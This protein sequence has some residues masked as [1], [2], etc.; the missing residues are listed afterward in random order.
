[1]TTST[2]TLKTLTY[3]ITS[4]RMVNPRDIAWERRRRRRRRRRK[5]MSKVGFACVFF[6]FVCLLVLFYFLQRKLCCFL[7]KI[8][9]QSRIS[10]PHACLYSIIH[11][12]PRPSTAGCSPLPM[13]SNCLSFA[14]LDHVAPCL[15]TS[16][17]LQSHFCLLIDDKPP[18]ICHSV[19]LIIHPSSFIQAMCPA[20]FRFLLLT[21]S[22]MSVALV[23]CQMMVFLILSFY[24]F[25]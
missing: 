13:A 20:H 22:T 12:R 25:Y 24:C 17:S 16:S 18:V 1:M 14:V 19:L 10:M 9:D 7:L 3:T 11:S 21:C 15:L 6:F 5:S 23:L 8:A 2:V 4:P